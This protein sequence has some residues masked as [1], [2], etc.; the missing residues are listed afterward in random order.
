[1]PS[2]RRVRLF[3]ANCSAKGDSGYRHRKSAGARGVSKNL[4]GRGGVASDGRGLLVVIA[5]M[6]HDFKFDAGVAEVFDDMVRRS[7]PFYDELQRMTVELARNFVQPGT[8]I[9]DVGC[10]TGQTLLSL[11][12]AIGDPSVTLIGLDNAPAMLERARARLAGAGAAGRCRFAEC[13]IN[14]GLSVGSGETSVAILN[15]TLQFVRPPNRA[16]VIRSICNA[17]APGA[18][19]IVM[20][21]IVTADSRLNRLYIDLHLEFKRRS[22]YSEMEIA[23]KRESLENV[24]VPYR[25]EE[26]LC[27]LEENGFATADVFFRWYNWAGLLAVKSSAKS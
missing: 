1:M 12:E 16:A 26:N 2:Y 4:A 5:P 25:V 23:E 15:W 7:V 6:A 20:E 9:V 21:K 3:F 10:A 17:L 24:L 11:A 13:D 8:A 27:L 22:G 14:D 18:C 19:L